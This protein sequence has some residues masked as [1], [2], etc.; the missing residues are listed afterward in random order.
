[1]ARGQEEEHEAY[2]SALRVL[3]HRVSRTW[4]IFKTLADSSS[5]D[6]HLTPGIGAA[7]LQKLKSA[8]ICTVYVPSLFQ[9]TSS[10]P[11]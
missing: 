11:A 7:D 4:K 3:T 8:G 9:S 10:S 1:M 5:L 6:T 2:L